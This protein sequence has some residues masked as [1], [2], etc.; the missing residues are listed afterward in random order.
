[1][2]N[3]DD[4][5]E[6]Q[7]G[8]QARPHQT[9]PDHQPDQRT[10]VVTAEMS[11]LPPSQESETPLDSPGSSP[12]LKDGELSSSSSSHQDEKMSQAQP[13][14]DTKRMASISEKLSRISSRRSAPGEDED[15]EQGPDPSRE[16]SP[17]FNRINPLKRNPPPVPEERIVSREY[18]AGFFSKLTFHWIQPLMTVGFQCA[19]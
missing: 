5:F 11:T 9:S 12:G 1:M 19:P 4:S 7:G 6:I 10:V 3:Q 13:H 16:K 2:S 18:S 17:W 15:E 8:R 14:N